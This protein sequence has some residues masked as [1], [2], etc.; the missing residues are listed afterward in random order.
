METDF[1]LLDGEALTG[2]YDWFETTYNY[3][4]VVPQFALSIELWTS[5]NEEDDLFINHLEIDDVND[6]HDLDGKRFLFQEDD[7]NGEYL[8][9][10]NDDLLVTSIQME[11]SIQA[12]NIIVS[13]NAWLRNEGTWLQH[14][15][16]FQRTYPLKPTLI[17]EDRI[18][19]WEKH[20]VRGR[21]KNW[22]R[23]MISTT[24]LRALQDMET[25]LSIVHIMQRR[26]TA[27]TNPDLRL[28]RESFRLEEWDIILPIRSAIRSLEASRRWNSQS[29]DAVVGHGE[30]KLMTAQARRL[31]RMLGNPGS[32]NPDQAEMPGPRSVST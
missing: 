12:E 24:R 23:D 9:R 1:I 13:G 8:F 17:I 16:T 11:F 21:I 28:F 15:L 10:K 25:H 4:W 7:M 29:F 30:W 18:Q 14:T 27:D 20:A 5:E 26:F 2:T 32:C 31:Y 19:E 22:A 3:R 6:I